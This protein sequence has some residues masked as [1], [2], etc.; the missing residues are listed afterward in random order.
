MTPEALSARLQV[1]EQEILRL[2]QLA[3]QET[4][5]ERQ[6]KFWQLAQD[7]QREVRE[8]RS[9][10]IKLMD[11]EG[12]PESSLAADHTSSNPC[13]NRSPVKTFSLETQTARSPQAQQTGQSQNLS[14]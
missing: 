12:T 8:I 11:S 5:S 14:A 4:E 7:L 10:I 1:L 2:T 9:Q 13:P 6:D 3:A